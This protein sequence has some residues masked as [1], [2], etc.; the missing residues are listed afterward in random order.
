MKSRTAILEV[1][2][3]ET[4]R[5]NGE[6]RAIVA[7]KQGEIDKLEAQIAERRRLIA[8][9]Q[10]SSTVEVIFKSSLARAREPLEDDV[11]YAG[12]VAS[13]A[14]RYDATRSRFLYKMAR[15][16]AGALVRV[17]QGELSVA[18]LEH[19]LA[20]GAFERSRSLPLTAPA[21][22]LVLHRVFYPAANEPFSIL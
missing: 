9:T 17:G 21:H 20:H 18:D 10:T 1:E 15:N 3:E 7:T 22:G 4:A 16:L 12:E 19:A 11:S 14:D 6:L 5:E 8:E 2:A 13:V